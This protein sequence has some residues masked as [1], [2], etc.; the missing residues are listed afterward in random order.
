M[1]LTAGYSA[2]GVPSLGRTSAGLVLS[3]RILQNVVHNNYYADQKGVREDYSPVDGQVV[4]VRIVQHEGI[5]ATSRTVGEN[6]TTG[7][8]TYFNANDRQQPAHNEFMLD[9][10]EVFDRVQVIPQ[11]MEDVVSINIL[12]THSQRI[13]QR[14][15]QLLN[16][17][18]MA[19]QIAASLNE[20]ASTSAGTHL[21][22][23]DDTA[24]SI[25]DKFFE[26]SLALDN[27]D[28]DNF[29]DAFD[30][31]GRVAIFSNY[32][33]KE[34]FKTEKSI[35]Q[36]GASRAIELLEIGSAGTMQPV[37]TQADGY[38]GELSNTPLHAAPGV[39]LSLVDDYLDQGG[40]I[41]DNFVGLIAGAEGTARGYGVPRSIK[42][43]DTVG[44]QG[45][46]LQPL[47][48]WGA[49][50]LYPKSIALIFKSGFVNPAETTPLEV[51]GTEA[52]A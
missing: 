17:Y 37:R 32:G 21:L 27:G 7:N 30:E 4:Q 48:R 3:Q 24:D 5:S 28:E 51:L 34:W 14:V 20:E 31:N 23:Y 18:T 40:T 44:G 49:K 50:V 29:I 9:L 52:V 15:R 19:K 1:A 45:I 36:A 13:E 35:F 42:M 2:A 12:N 33:K 10:N 22:T 8:N 25:M 39:I 38:F 16:A 41:K 6:G 47:V 26:A 43:V 11:L 46:E